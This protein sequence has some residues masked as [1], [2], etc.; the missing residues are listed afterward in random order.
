MFRHVVMFQW[1]PETSAAQQ[2]ASIAAMREM[3]E[4]IHDLGMLSIGVD[5]GLAPGNFDIVV[6]ADFADQDDYLRYTKDPRHTDVV[7][8]YIKPYV[9]S[10]AAVQSGDAG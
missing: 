9:A 6:V 1:D 3:A 5:A 4:E 7:R 10:R 2:A 8:D